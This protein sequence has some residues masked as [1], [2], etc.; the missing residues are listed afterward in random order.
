M[1]SELY[2]MKNKRQET[3]L[4]TFD[5]IIEKC[6]AKIKMVATQGGMNVF[7]EVPYIVIGF[8][9]YKIEECV[10]Y[11]VDALRKNGLMVQVLPHPNANTVYISWKPA[12]IKPQNHLQYTPSL[13]G[14]PSK[15][16][17]PFASR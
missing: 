17:N 1:L 13:Q 6:H 10:E 11:I 15:K 14:M 2:S 5:H 4:K 3:K 8:P 16:F 7:F 12:D 9:L